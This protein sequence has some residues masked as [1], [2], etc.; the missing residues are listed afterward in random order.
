VASTQLPTSMGMRPLR[1]RLTTGASPSSGPRQRYGGHYGCARARVAI[2]LKR[3]AQHSYPLSH[4]R[5]ADPLARSAFQ[6]TQRGG[7]EP[8]PV[9]ADLQPDLLVYPPQIYAHPLCLSVLADVGSRFLGDAEEGDLDLGRQALVSEM[10]L[11]FDAV[12]FLIKAFDLQG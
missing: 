5:K 1:S 6:C 2:D 4:P 9:V 10:F 11:V 8:A 3:A 12:A 7:V